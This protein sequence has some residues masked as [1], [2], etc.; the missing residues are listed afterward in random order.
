MKSKIALLYMF[1]E[2]FKR[3][4]VFLSGGQGEA[5]QDRGINHHKLILQ[6]D[7]ILSHNSLT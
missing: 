1:F 5:N 4:S 7:I 2:T 3:F 6:F